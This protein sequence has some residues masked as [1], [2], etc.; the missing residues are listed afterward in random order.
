MKRKQITFCKN[1][2][3]P[4]LPEM[5]G[6]YSSAQHCYKIAFMADHL[7][8]RQKRPESPSYKMVLGCAPLL[9]F[10]HWTARIPTLYPISSMFNDSHLANRLGLGILITTMEQLPGPSTNRILSH[11]SRKHS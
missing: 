4:I 3:S 1:F 5:K 9:F 7:R 8:C 2:S 10:L 11:I 6:K